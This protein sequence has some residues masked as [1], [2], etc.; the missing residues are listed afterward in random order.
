MEIAKNALKRSVLLRDDL[1]KGT[2]SGG[3]VRLWKNPFPFTPRHNPQ[4]QNQLV[5]TKGLLGTDSGIVQPSARD[6]ALSYHV[7]P[8]PLPSCTNGELESMEA[9]PTS[10]ARFRRPCPWVQRQIAE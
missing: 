2:K 3:A 5:H 7:H 8:D 4:W 9:M 6:D 10:G 1:P